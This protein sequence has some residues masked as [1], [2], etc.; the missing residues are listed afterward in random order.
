MSDATDAFREGLAEGLKIA[1]RHLEHLTQ[2]PQLASETVESM[3]S[4][5][6]AFQAGIAVNQ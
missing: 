2:D 3:R 5:I 4:A 6:S 1:V